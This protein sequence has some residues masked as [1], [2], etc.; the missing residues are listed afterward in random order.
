MICLEVVAGVVHVVSPQPIDLS[1]CSLVA[2]SYS[3]MTSELTRI[4][5]AEGAQIAGAILLIWAM[6]W[7]VRV[8]ARSINVGDK[9]E[10]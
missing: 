10:F 3:E 2:G 1:A 6:G 5:P 9:E 7:V 8:A 4:S